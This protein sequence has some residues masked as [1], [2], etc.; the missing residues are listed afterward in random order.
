MEAIVT[1]AAGMAPT[2][3]V[4]R[5]ATNHNHTVSSC[6]ITHISGLQFGSQ[7]GSGSVHSGNTTGGD[8][9]ASVH[10]Y[11]ADPRPK[12]EVK[13]ESSADAPFGDNQV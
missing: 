12:I 3:L 11:D 5:M 13:M 2:I 10:V 1:V 9:N 8:I 4:A 6:T 7:Q